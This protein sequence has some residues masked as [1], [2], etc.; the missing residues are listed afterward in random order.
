MD[1]VVVL[2]TCFNRCEMTQRC[3]KSLG[4]LNE[5]YLMR[6]VIVNDGS[7]DGTGEMLQKLS[8][9]HEI[10]VL[11]GDGSLYY[12]GGMIKGMEYILSA[13]WEF[14]YLL[15]VNDDVNFLDNCVENMIIK[16][17]KFGNAV[18]VGTTYD[19]RGQLNYGAVK[20]KRKGSLKYRKLSLEE[21]E[22][23]ADTFNGNCVLIPRY[24]FFQIG[25]MDRMY[26]HKWGEFDYG[27]MIKRAGYKIFISAGYVGQCNN[28]Q[29]N[30]LNKNKP[31]TQRLKEKESPKGA[32]FRQWFHYLY[33]NY[34]LGKAVTRCWTPYIKL[35][36]G[37]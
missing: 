3:I 25:T 22:V 12:T 20:F 23:E 7:N 27:M 35:I 13:E 32:P 37:K 1:K 18:I 19:E 6:F 4:K 10:D 34:G 15:L 24:I 31:F 29:E 5:H 8:E 26:T 21:Q 30:Y 28:N 2:F 9:E 16:S 17:R 11:L 36:L 33:K 14:T